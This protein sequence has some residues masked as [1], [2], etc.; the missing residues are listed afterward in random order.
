MS[1][2]RFPSTVAVSV[3]YPVLPGRETPVAL[4]RLDSTAPSGL[5]IWGS[6]AMGRLR[7]ELSGIDTDAVEAVVVTGNHKSFG[8]GADLKE[9]RDAQLHGGS[10]D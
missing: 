4:V 7:S 1:P 2:Q 10:E 8:A 3:E 6:E 5:V 9:I